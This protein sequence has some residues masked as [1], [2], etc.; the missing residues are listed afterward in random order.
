LL[1]LPQ[2][3]DLGALWQHG[4]AV[5]RELSECATESVRLK[6]ALAMVQ[7]ADSARV[8]QSKPTAGEV[9]RA[10]EKLRDVYRKVQAM[11]SSGSPASNRAE[12]LVRSVTEAQAPNADH[13]DA[14]ECSLAKG[15]NDPC[16]D[17]LRKG[18]SAVLQE[19]AKEDSGLQLDCLSGINLDGKA[20][21][22]APLPLGIGNLGATVQD[23]VEGL[24]A[25]H[26]WRFVPI[27]GTFPR[28]LRRKLMRIQ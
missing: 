5:L 22:P 16:A 21:T 25:T 8:L 7:A 24:G 14:D 20:L 23:S 10:L 4:V 15:V 6:C 27:P 9:E 3:F 28:R 26:E 13:E 12:T 17:T 11:E 18:S 2:A 1:S 19:V